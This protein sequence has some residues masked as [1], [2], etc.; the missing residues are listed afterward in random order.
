MW[1]VGRLQPAADRL[2]LTDDAQ[3]Q[4]DGQAHRPG[5][6]RHGQRVRGDLAGRLGHPVRLDHRHAGTR[7]ESIGHR[8]RQGRRCRPDEPDAR[9]NGLVG[10]ERAQARD[11][12]GHR[13][14]PRDGATGHEIPEPAAVEA[15]VEDQA[16]AGHQ[17][18]QQTHDLGVD[19]EEGQRIE[20]AVLAP[21]LQVR[22]HAASRV[23]Q[24]APGS[25]GPPWA[26]RWCPTTTGRHRPRRPAGAPSPRA[27]WRARPPGARG[28]RAR[29]IRRRS[30]RVRGDR[31]ARDPR[32]CA[33]GSPPGHRSPPT[34]REG[35]RGAT[36]KPALTAPRNASANAT[37]SST[38]RP[39]VVR[40]RARGPP[41]RARQR[42]MLRSSWRKDTDAS[43]RAC[44]T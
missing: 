24:L 2:G 28:D 18:R 21:E 39:M 11:D 4:P 7:L 31:P 8:H 42:S 26:C 40:P 23:Q 1:N 32:P 33:P 38:R 22:R 6:A 10:P 34:G 43:A 35:S 36:Q 27:W 29:P 13:V 12:G 41:S 37:G 5:A 44:S 20:P 30:H 3:L 9:G 15:V 19:V 16:R 17:G 14:D 25:T